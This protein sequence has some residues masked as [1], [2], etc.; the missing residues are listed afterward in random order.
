M[1]NEIV[2]TGSIPTI[3]NMYTN[4]KNG[5][6][7]VSKKHAQFKL[8]IGWLAKHARVKL[9]TGKVHLEIFAHFGRKGRDISNIIKPIEDSL[10]G[11][12]YNDDSQ[13]Y[14]GTQIKD[15]SGSGPEMLIIRGSEL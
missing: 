2:Y 5:K 13:I 4:A 15:D 14:K 9:I 8:D 1:T 3:N 12:M 11:I 6:R 7:V 10:K